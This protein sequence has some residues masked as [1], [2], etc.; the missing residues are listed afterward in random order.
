M[1][2]LH[3]QVSGRGRR[4][5][6]LLHGWGMNL[7]IWDELAHSLGRR[8]RVIAIDR[9]GSGYSQRAPGASARLAA[10]GDLIAKFISA[11]GLER[12]L[13]VGHSLGGAIALALRIVGD[14]QRPRRAWQTRGCG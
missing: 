5:L 14:T 11:L 7:R 1:S 6:V 2:A 3:A 13:V 8:F 9:P 10:Q 4:D 12:P